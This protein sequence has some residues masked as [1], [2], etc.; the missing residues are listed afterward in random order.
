MHVTCAGRRQD[1][2]VGIHRADG[3]GVRPARPGAEVGRA[4]VSYENIVGLALSVL[5]ALYLAGA[6]LF[7]GEVLVSTTTAGIIFL[8]VLVAGAGAG[9]R[10]PRRLHVPGV[11]VGEGLPRRAG[12]LPADRGRPAL[13]ADLG[14]IRAK[15]VG[16]L[17]DQHPVPVRL[18]ARAGQVAVASA[19]SGHP[20]DACAGVE[21]RGQL[22]HQH[23]LAGLLGESTDGHLVQMAGL[24]VQNFVSAAVG[25]A[26]AI[27][28]VRGFA[29]KRTGDLGNFWVDLVRARC[30]DPA[31]D[32]GRRRD[33]ADRRRG[34]PELP[35]AR[36]DRQHAGGRPADDHRGPVASQ[37]AI[38]ELGT[39]G[40]GFYN[41][42]S[43]HPFENPTPWTNWLEIF[44][45]LA[46]SFSLP[47]TFGAHGRQHEAGLGDRS[48]HGDR[49]CR[50]QR[51]R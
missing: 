15:R 5:L 7:P 38:K 9:A 26:V 1:G 48:G 34:D 35:S 36:P 39:N 40:G 46:I 29:R 51:D 24:A 47:R 50:D 33:R 2:R 20:D 25:I 4:A 45:L 8:V 18:P 30:C 31:A 16:V 23:Q 42:N 49:C 22:H 11:H 27:A 41:A 44:L 21:H 37:E 28:L 3:G 17:V 14:R 43:S 19:Q 13:G 32:F 10:A 6:L 12:D